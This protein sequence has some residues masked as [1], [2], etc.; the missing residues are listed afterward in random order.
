MK[1]C[2][3]YKLM[4]IKCTRDIYSLID[5]WHSHVP[6]IDPYDID[7]K[8]NN[9]IELKIYYDPYIDG[10]RCCTVGSAWFDNQP[11]MIFRHA[12][13]SGH[14]AYD[15][16]ITDKT[17]YLEMVQYLRSL[18]SAECEDVIDPSE[19]IEKLDSFYGHLTF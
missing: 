14:D 10:D 6:E 1:P 11:V 5:D 7:Y 12:G 18:S 8:L 9:R 19:N 3:I 17:L 15:R 13:R 4:P 16:F 2:D